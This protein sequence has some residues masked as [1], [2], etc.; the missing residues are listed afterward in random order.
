MPV[1]LWSSDATLTFHAP[2]QPS[3]VSHSATNLQDTEAVIA[4]LLRYSKSEQHAPI[5]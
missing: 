2:A 3:F 5:V 1:G 4:A